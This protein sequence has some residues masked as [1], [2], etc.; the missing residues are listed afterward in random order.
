MR[1]T[2]PRSYL[3]SISTDSM[4]KIFAVSRKRETAFL[5]SHL[6]ELCLPQKNKN[7]MILHTKNVVPRNA[8]N[9]QK[10]SVVLF[11]KSFQCNTNKKMFFLR[12]SQIENQ[13][14]EKLYKKFF[15]FL[16][17]KTVRHCHFRH[18]M[19]DYSSFSSSSIGF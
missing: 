12:T 14:A 10:T 9:F 13:K 16:L 11:S 18:F 8:E 15:R 2:C 3:K 19:I 6:K 4:Q 17:Y 7:Y 1:F 5:F